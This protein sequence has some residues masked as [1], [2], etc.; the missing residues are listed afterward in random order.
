MLDHVSPV[1][2]AHLPDALTDILDDEPTFER[3][4]RALRRHLHM[5]PEVGM[6]EEQTSAFIRKTLEGYGLD[7]Q[8]PVASTGLFVDIVGAEDGP[9]VG[10]RADIDALPAHDQKQVPYRSQVPNA[11]HL[12]GHDAHTTVAIGVALLLHARR[13]ELAGTVRVFFQPN[14]EGLPSGAPL[15]IRSGVLNGLSAVYGIHVEPKLDVGCYGLRV[16]PITAASDRFDVQ[17][18]QEGTGHSARPHEGADT[19]WIATQ[20]M[21]Q[22]YQLV[23]RVTDA[24]NPAVLTICKMNGSEAH[25][26]IPEIATFGGTLRTVDATDR[27]IIRRHM[28]QTAQELGALY[29]A[30]VE[31]HIEDGAPAVVNDEALIE[32]IE[33]TVDAMFGAE[34]IH[35]IPDT[36]MGGEDFAHYLKHVPGAFLRVGTRSGPET[37]YPLHHHHFNI[38]ERALAPTA[39][40]MAQVLANHTAHRVTGAAAVSDGRPGAKAHTQRAARA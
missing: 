28:R 14:E 19:V 17:V 23:G 7:V 38:D 12:C 33:D 5:H 11:A 15:M 26:V 27:E 20:I 34:A 10:Y 4:L 25:N 3:L 2:A 18:R 8:G 30:R 22:F 1:D 9:K 13:D 29:G 24:R 32:N 40:L 35:W 21:Q 36:S 31:L 37:R 6:K 16:G 39:R